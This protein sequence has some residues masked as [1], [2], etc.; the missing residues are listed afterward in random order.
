MKR[1]LSLILA[2]AMLA[3]VVLT[4][5]SCGGLSGTYESSLGTHELKFSG[6]K[7][8]VIMGEN[9]LEGSY[10]ITED[11]EGNKKISFDFIDEEDATEDQK[12]VLKVVDA[13][14]GKPLSLVEKDDT[15]KI[16]SIFTYKK[17]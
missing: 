12:K 16:G 13:L 3:C 2:V 8:T 7:V 6:S 1:T 4:L 14:L 11:E 10:E 17:K 15:I 5:V 9:E